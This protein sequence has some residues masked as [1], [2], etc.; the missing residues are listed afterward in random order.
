M[1][2]EALFNPSD[3]GIRQSGVAETAGRCLRMF[4]PSVRELLSNN[5]VLTG[6]NTKIPFFRERFSYPD[7]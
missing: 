2:P 3:I 5:I 1:V 6:G 7:E 4:A